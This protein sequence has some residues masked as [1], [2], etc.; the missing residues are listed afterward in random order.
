LIERINK[1]VNHYGNDDIA[2]GFNAVKW[3]IEHNLIHQGFILLQ[4]TVVTCLIAMAGL[5]EKK[6]INNYKLR[7][8]FKR[9]IEIRYNP[10]TRN[11]QTLTINMINSMM[12]DQLKRDNIISG[13]CNLWSDMEESFNLP[14]NVK[15]LIK[16]YELIFVNNY[17]YAA[18]DNNFV[19]MFIDELE[20]RSF[21]GYMPKDK[22][23]SLI[24]FVGKCLTGFAKINGMDIKYS[25]LMQELSKVRNNL[26][27]GGFNDREISEIINFR[28]KWNP[29]SNLL[30]KDIS[31]IS[32]IDI[33]KDICG[34]MEDIVNYAR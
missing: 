20:G 2:N 19:K 3:C 8:I 23:D 26:A 9:A 4:E 5:E 14:D 6:F 27:H 22:A 18:I 25:C 17:G 21:V 24:G 32:F 11:C 13:L 1:T 30:K 10:R 7:S 29:I 31:K 15:N 16:N 34:S 33:L 12:K 28:K